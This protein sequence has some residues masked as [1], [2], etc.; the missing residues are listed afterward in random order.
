[1]IKELI[2]LAEDLDR[3]G[4][5]QEADRIDL[6]LRRY[7]QATSESS[8]PQGAAAPV[9]ATQKPKPV[10]M[11]ELQK[12]GL[13]RLGYQCPEDSD[14]IGEFKLQDFVKQIQE[15]LAK[16]PERAKCIYAISIFEADSSGKVSSSKYDVRVHNLTKDLPGLSKVLS[17]FLAPAA[18]Q[19]KVLSPAEKMI[20]DGYNSYKLKFKQCVI[21]AV[22][23]NPSFTASTVISFTVNKDGST[24]NHKAV[25]TPV[26][27]SFDSCLASQMLSWSFGRISLNPDPRYGE[28]SIESPINVSYKQKF[29]RE[30]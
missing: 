6:M 16:H 5:I 12:S 4:N 15:D 25:S 10:E 14:R 29:G 18:P 8:S 26:N 23:A 20:E 3:A 24:S 28:I 21:T 27:P 13:Y 7:A 17:G 1:M 22:N 2:K 9:V 30:K 11:I 19:Q